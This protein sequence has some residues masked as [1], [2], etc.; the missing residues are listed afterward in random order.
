MSGDA[1]SRTSATYYAVLEND[2]VKN[3]MEV[4]TP[5]DDPVSDS[6]VP[7]YAMVEEKNK[8]SISTPEKTHEYTRIC[9]DLEKNEIHI[10]EKA[11]PSS[12]SCMSVKQS[13]QDKGKSKSE[14]T[15]RARRLV[16]RDLLVVVA[17]V[18]LGAVIASVVFTLVEVSA[19]KSDMN[20]L[21]QHINMTYM[22]RSDKFASMFQSLNMLFKA[23]L[24]QVNN[25]LLNL[26]LQQEKNT[27][28]LIYNLQNSGL[29]ITF[30]ATSCA[31]VLLFAPSLPSG[32]YWIRSSN[33]S[34]VRVYCDMTRSCGNITGGWMR[35]AEL[36]MTDTAIQCPSN[37]MLLTNG[38]SRTCIPKTSAAACTSVYYPTLN[39]YSHVCGMIK[40]YPIGSPEGFKIYGQRPMATTNPN[41]STNY[42][43]GV[44]M[45]HGMNPRDHI[46][47]MSFYGNSGNCSCEINRPSFVASDFFCYGNHCMMRS[48]SPW[49]YKQLPDQPT[50]DDIEMR[51]CRDEP[52]Q[53]EDI[54]IEAIEFYI[55]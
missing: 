49:F 6:T 39:T 12:T 52:R 47:T 51:V 31:S 1:F 42:V 15:A 27:Q 25:S 43:D 30:P 19:I 13:L 55:R 23:S 20:S 2:K 16:T 33:G 32:D 21:Q 24:S 46:W 18:L 53:N 38:N 37:L 14:D 48:T 40:A 29:L 9:T 28:E 45:T 5:K 50:N 11:V 34:A 22:N 17:P 4:H 10:Y 44:S 26:S 36:D 7:L 54:A 8:T 41:I 3:N 35:V